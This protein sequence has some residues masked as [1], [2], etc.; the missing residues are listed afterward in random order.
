MDTWES[1]IKERMR[2]CIAQREEDPV[3]RNRQL[4]DQRRGRSDARKESKRRYREAHRDELNEKKR[5][6]NASEQGAAKNRAYG[7]EYR[8][9]NRERERKRKAEW[10][11]RR[12]PNPRPVGRPR[13]VVDAG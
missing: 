5:A 2:P 6:Y 13:K 9:R 12:H 7:K 11:R 8:E 1:L 3:K 4:R 10:W